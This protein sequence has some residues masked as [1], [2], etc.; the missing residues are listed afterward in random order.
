MIRVSRR[1]RAIR[2]ERNHMIL[3]STLVAFA[4]LFTCFGIYVNDC[5]HADTAAVDAFVTEANIE[6]RVLTD[7]S[8]AYIPDVCVAGV[9][10]Y[11]GGKVEAAAYIPLMRA[12]AE[13]GILAV[14][15]EMPFNLAVLKQSAANGIKE[16]L[17]WVDNWYMA[18][19]SLGGSMAASYAA[20]NASG[21]KGVILLGAYSTKNLSESGLKALSIYGSLDT[22]LTMEK[23]NSSK[24]NLPADFTEAVIEGG[25]H[26]GFGMYG[27]QDGDTEATITNAAQINETAK[28]IAEFVK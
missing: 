2:Q 10:F 13:Q 17:F 21:Y 27:L 24:V 19:H 15:V 23:Y 3:V 16:Q 28:I 1:M 14:L 4:I 5:Y 11:P 18:G 7:G 20:K 26:S 9:I 8:V 25:N 12:L 22:V 6:E